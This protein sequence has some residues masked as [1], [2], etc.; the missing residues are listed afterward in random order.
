[1]DYLKTEKLLC[2][3]KYRF[4][5]KRSTKMAATLFCDR[6][7]QQMDSGKLIGAIY[8]D[9][10]KAFDTIGHNVL[11]DKL[12]KFGIGGKSLD[13]F[14][15]YLLNRSQTI[16]SNGCRSGVEPIVWGVPQGSILGPFLFIMFYNDFPDHIQSCE[17]IIYADDTVIFCANKDPTV[18]ENQLNKDME[19]VKNYCFMNELIINTTKGKTE[20]MLFGTSK[21]LKS[22]EKRPEITFSGKQINFLTKYKYLGVI[23]DDTMTLNDN[24][25]RTYKAASTRLQ[26]L[27]KMKSFTTVKARYVIYTSV[28]IPLLTYSCPIQ[29]TFT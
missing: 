22:S 17:V 18:I 16:E 21:R 20:V 5:R 2:N 25:N 10:T 28:I 7:R 3:Q 11:I 29:L 1:M 14:V 23:I 27:G 4:R 6:I 13:W 15:D 24:F 19:N 12:P 8:L 9:L 26:L